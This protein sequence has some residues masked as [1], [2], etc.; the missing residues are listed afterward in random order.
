MVNINGDT[1]QSWLPDRAT[2]EIWGGKRITLNWWQIYLLIL[3]T[4]VVASSLLG[5]LIGLAARP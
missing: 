5:C 2:I 3:A 1:H 4:V